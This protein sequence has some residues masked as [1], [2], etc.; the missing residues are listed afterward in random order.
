MK[1][2]PIVKI[3]TRE[4]NCG[5]LRLLRLNK[6]SEIENIIFGFQKNT[7]RNKETDASSK[8]AED[9]SSLRVKWGARRNSKFSP[10]KNRQIRGSKERAVLEWD[11]KLCKSTLGKECN[12]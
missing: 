6:L 2:N 9:S 4:F 10:G 3:N 1:Q 7:Y 12:F 5:K 8:L 11:I